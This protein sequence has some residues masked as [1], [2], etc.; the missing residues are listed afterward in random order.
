MDSPLIT[1][2]IL[3]I[4]SHVKEKEELCLFS[5]SDFVG[6]TPTC[7]RLPSK[8]KKFQVTCHHM[9]VQ[10]LEEYIMRNASREFLSSQIHSLLKKRRLRGTYTSYTPVV[11]AKI[12]KWALENGNKSARNH[13]L[14]DFPNLNESTVRNFKKAYEERM[15]WQRK[16]LHPITSN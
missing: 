6:V 16:Q 15:K 4:V 12:G 9:K 5:N 3:L 10:D 14:K 1:L 11:W 2:S 13:F 7:L 8:V